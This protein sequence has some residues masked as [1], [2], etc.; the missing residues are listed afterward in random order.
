MVCYRF[1]LRLLFV[2]F[3]LKI[4]VMSKTCLMRVAELQGFK[5]PGFSLCDFHKIVSDDV[6]KFA[7]KLLVNF[8]A[9]AGMFLNDR[10]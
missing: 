4:R 1:V 3:L 2:F 9:V 7:N 8:R 6:V 5:R 10:L